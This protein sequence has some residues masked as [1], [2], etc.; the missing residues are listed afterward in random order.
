ME[1]KYITMLIN[2]ASIQNDGFL[3]FKVEENFNF[4]Y[5]IILLKQSLEKKLGKIEVRGNPEID[6][7][8]EYHD[9][10]FHLSYNTKNIYSS[11]ELCNIIFTC[12]EGKVKDYLG[13]GGPYSFCFNPNFNGELWVGAYGLNN[14]K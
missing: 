13:S 10:S 14:E 11:D 3:S 6:Y 1:N 9:I 7:S 8:N 5:E 12:L 4:L 2:N